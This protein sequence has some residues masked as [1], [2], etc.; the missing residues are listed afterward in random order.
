M[1]ERDLSRRDLMIFG[2]ATALG[3]AMQP[4]LAAVSGGRGYGVIALE[5][6]GAVIPVHSA[7]GGGWVADVAVEDIGRTGSPSKRPTVWRSTDIVIEVPP[8]AAGPLGQWI[9]DTMAGTARPRSGALAYHAAGGPNAQKRLQFFDA[10]LTQVEMPAA[11]ASVRGPGLMTLTLTP[12]RTALVGAGPAAQVALGAKQA[13]TVGNFAFSVQG[14]EKA[15]LRV[16]SVSAPSFRRAVSAASPGGAARRGD[17]SGMPGRPEFGT[18]TI[19]LADIESDAGAYF[20][21]MMDSQNGKQTARPGR[22]VWLSPDLRTPLLAVQWAN[23]NITGFQ[24]SPRGNQEAVASVQVDMICD[25][26]KIEA[27]K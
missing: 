14:L 3:V 25:S 19:H 4:A 12:A 15:S 2:G 6:D 8:T 22:L 20:Q 26:W 27:P 24:P 10:V 21:W 17:P 7:S 13:I 5:V 11:D 18:V 1:A 23:L 9:A 16:H